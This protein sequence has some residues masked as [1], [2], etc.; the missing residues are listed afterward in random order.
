[1]IVNFYIRKS[2]RW[3]VANAEALQ[4]G[5][6]KHGIQSNIESSLDYQPCDLAIV[7]GHKQQYIAAG[8]KDHGADYLVMERA[9]LGKTSMY[10]GQRL[11]SISLGFN[12]LSGRATFY[13]SADP[14]RGKRFY[15]LILPSHQFVENSGEYYL[16]CGQMINDA[17]VKPHIDYPTWIDSLPTSHLGKPVFYRIHPQDTRLLP[18]YEYLPSKHEVLGGDLI[19]SLQKSSAAWMWNSTCGVDA[20]LA[21]VP[22]VAFDPGSMVYDLAA[23]SIHDDPVWPDREKMVNELA[24]CQW[25]LSELED[26]T[27]WDH[28]KQHYKR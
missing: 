27:A 21:G 16:I 20:I 24:W 25:Q 13:K 17:A 7:W 22:A 26:G 28:L 1:M 14:S 5:L 19:E 6:L 9:F 2:S 4:A 15:D 3:H 10:A 23:H 12:G 11:S 8:Q 18:D